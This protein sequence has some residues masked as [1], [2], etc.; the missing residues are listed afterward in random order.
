MYAAEL[1]DRKYVL[2]LPDIEIA[3]ASTI[4][5]IAPKMYL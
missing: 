1:R 3:Y 2:I 4:F 5:P